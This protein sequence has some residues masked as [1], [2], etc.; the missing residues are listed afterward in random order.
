M[1]HANFIQTQLKISHRSHADRHQQY[2]QFAAAHSIQ[3]PVT[4]PASDDLFD[5]D[6]IHAESQLARI[7]GLSLSEFVK[8]V[9]GQSPADTRP[10]KDLFELPLPDEPELRQITAMWNEIVKHGVQPVWKSSRPGVQRVRPDNHRLTG[11]YSTQIRRHINEGYK[12]GRY[13]ILEDDLLD[14]WPSIFISPI[15]VVS[16]TSSDPAVVRVI[17]DY[18]FPN[19][20]SV[21]DFTDRVNFPEIHYNP[22]ADIARRIFEL[23]SRFP[24]HPLVMMLGDVAGAFRHVPVH[25]D[26]VHMFAFRFEGKIVIDLSLGFGWCGSPAFYSL[27]GTLI[28]SLYEHSYPAASLN[29]VDR[30]PFSGNVWCDDHTCVEIA[31]GTRCAEANLAL[32]SAMA[33]VLGP[34]ALNEEKLRSGPSGLKHLDYSGI[35]PPDQF[36]FL[37]IRFTKRTSGSKVF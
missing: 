20:A 33:T 14:V 12:E 31:V 2:Q 7:S 29:T 18:A 27:A 30:S 22:P 6:R 24:D 9:R 15:G 26:H 21:N 3:L 17:N 16:K 19:E 35:Q 32:R 13:L 37:Q 11:D 1:A 10:N 28:N 8:R 25:A 23:R 36:L 5:L 4:H 34:N